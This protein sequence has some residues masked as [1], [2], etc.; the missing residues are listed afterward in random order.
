M[1]LTYNEQLITI[2]LENAIKEMYDFLL[3]LGNPNAIN[4]NDEKIYA[5][6]YAKI[7][8]LSIKVRAEGYKGYEHKNPHKTLGEFLKSGKINDFVLKFYSKPV[9]EREIIKKP[10]ALKVIDGTIK[11]GNKI[12]SIFKKSQNR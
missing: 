4:L 11:R 5:E 8:K 10:L 1:P 9:F 7:G 12:A 2:Q 3:A 6:H